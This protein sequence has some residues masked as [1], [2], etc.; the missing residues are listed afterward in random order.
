MKTYINPPKNSWEK[1]LERPTFSVRELRDQVESILADISIN[2]IDAIR[3]Y[4]EKFD[5]FSP[6]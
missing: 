1:L 4:T 5:G 3:K 2:G 6:T